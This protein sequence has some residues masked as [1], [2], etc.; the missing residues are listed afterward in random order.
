MVEYNP[1][2]NLNNIIIKYIEEISKM[3]GE[4]QVFSRTVQNE[5]LFYSLANIDAVHFSTKIEGNKLT[6]KQ[7]TKALTGKIKKNQFKYKRD[8]KEILNY[9]KARSF[10]FEKANKN[11]KLSLDLIIETHKI[12]QAGIVIGKLKGYLRLAQNVIKDA[13]TKSIIYI[14]PDFNEVEVLMNSLINW[15]NNALLNNINILL[16]ASIFH[17]QFVTIH[18]FMDGNGRTARLLTNYILYSNG[19]IVSKYA[20]IEKQQELDKGMYYSNL[21]KLQG[22]NYYDIPQNI[23]VSSWIEYWLS[24]LKRAY[25]EAL[26]R[27][28]KTKID[29]YE[30]L[31]L[32]NRLQKAINLFKRHKTLKAF[33]YQTLMGLARTQ[34]VSDLNELAK[35]N[36]IKKVGGGRS[37]V[38]TLK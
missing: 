16:I 23:N 33:D 12:L 5:L 34:A 19:H 20:S 27:I 2:Y 17:Y 36:I 30:I 13:K 8:L 22:N 21:R 15:V 31:T 1:I 6:I 9:S 37:T 25:E 28:E 26:N 3:Q 32:N 24:C 10:L 11:T 14:P 35:K 18:P 4:L 7:V 38:Y 29:N